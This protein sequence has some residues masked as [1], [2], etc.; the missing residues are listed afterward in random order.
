MNPLISIIVPNYNHELFLRKRLESVYNQSYEH[1]EVILLDDASTDKSV[2]ILKTYENHPK[3]AHLIVNNQNSGSPFKQWQKGIELANGE[4]I[5]IA[6][7]DDYAEPNFLELVSKPLV[8]NKEI[9]LA[10]C[11]SIIVDE[12]NNE[13]YINTKWTDDLNNLNCKK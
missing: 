7:S 3:T 8:E 10:Y 6:E 13:L 4:L 2:E 12:N 9:G 5:W 1:I 11:Q